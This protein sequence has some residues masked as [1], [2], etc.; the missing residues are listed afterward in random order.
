MS[1]WHALE[2]AGGQ[3]AAVEWREMVAP[4]WS[5][6]HPLFRRTGETVEFVCVAGNVRRVVVHSADH[7]VTVPEEGGHAIPIARSEVEVLRLDHRLLTR[8]IC[9][10]LGFKA[11]EGGSGFDTH[12]EVAR[13]QVTS[14]TVCP[15][16]LSVSDEPSLREGGIYRLLAAQREP[17]IILVPHA[18]LSPEAQ[19]VVRYARGCVL[20]L[21][22][23]LAV[24]ST[25]VLAKTDLAERTL[26]DFAAVVEHWE[27]G[28]QVEEPFLFEKVGSDVWCVAFHRKRGYVAQ[29]RAKGIPYIQHLL[30]QPHQVIDAPD[31][32]R[33]VEGGLPLGKPALGTEVVDAEDLPELEKALDGMRDDLQV[34]RED[35]DDAR[36][37]TLAEKVER[38][39]TYIATARGFNGRVRLVGDDL[40]RMRSRVS[41]AITRAIEVI[42]V[43]VP[44]LGVHL[45]KSL[46][47]GKTL[48]Y[49]PD[50]TFG[51]QFGRSG[52]SGV[53]V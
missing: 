25:G 33:M 4:D 44:A 49:T 24:S 7:I 18:P 34:A 1:L 28:V 10:A 37:A 8:W 40:E 5:W 50:V 26:G 30:A 9:D 19:I 21:A 16:Y 52:T 53:P 45:D 42:G 47:T 46:N 41:N 11:V 36:V 51:W 20:L 31:L 3:A 22:D 23:A 48:S 2:D 27:K 32:E 13:V 35:R 14:G 43:E 29:T 39:E 15:V 6:A 17:A 38:L 12:R